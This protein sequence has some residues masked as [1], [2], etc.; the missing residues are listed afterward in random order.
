MEQHISDTDTVVELVYYVLRFTEFSIQSRRIEVLD[1]TVKLSIL[2]I[3]D[4]AMITRFRAI[5]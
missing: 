2:P 1:D 4:T 5:K 3:P